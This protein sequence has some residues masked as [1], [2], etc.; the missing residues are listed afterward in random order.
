MGN[1]IRFPAPTGDV[2]PADLYLRLRADRR[3]GRSP[4][5]SEHERAEGRNPWSRS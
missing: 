2:D 5:P 1:L 3:N 4:E